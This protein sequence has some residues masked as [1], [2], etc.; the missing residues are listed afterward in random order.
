MHNEAQ[1]AWQIWNLTNQLND[2]IWD[3]YDKGLMQMIIDG[4]NEEIFEDL[5]DDEKMLLAAE[6]HCS[7]SRTRQNDP[8]PTP[9]NS[10]RTDK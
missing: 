10:R 1:I 3:R 5:A 7:V 9:F 6:S 4:E 8:S 2:M